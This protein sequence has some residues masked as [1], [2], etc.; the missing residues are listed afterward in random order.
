M[1]ERSV[2]VL[3]MA[4]YKTLYILSHCVLSC[5]TDCFTVCLL[6][7]FVNVL[8]V[9]LNEDIIVN[10]YRAHYKAL[11][12][13]PLYFTVYSDRWTHGVGKVTA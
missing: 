1:S 3:D 5:V 11:Y 9:S 6:L 4:L 10:I 2:C 13:C 7:R 8:T 12:R